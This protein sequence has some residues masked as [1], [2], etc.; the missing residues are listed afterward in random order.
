MEKDIKELLIV[1]IEKVQKSIDST[2]EAVE[3][4]KGF[5]AFKANNYDEQAP[6]DVLASRFTRAVEVCLKFFRTYELYTAR[7]AS[8]T[9]RDRLLNM[10]KLDLIS[11]TDLWLDMRDVRNRVVHD[12]LPEEVRKTF[13]LII[14]VYF[15]ELSE[16]KNKVSILKFE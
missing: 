7:V 5:D 16:L 8:D 15:K 12:Y 3:R 10:E 13:D 4:A 6:F 14:S 11:N 1:S 2:I 9:I